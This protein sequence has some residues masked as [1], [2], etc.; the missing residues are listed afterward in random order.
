VWKK[1]ICNEVKLID[2]GGATYAHESHTL[3]INTRQYR[4]PEV[5]L[6]NRSW[7]E[8]SDIWSMAC[9][10]VELYTGELFFDTHENNLEHL[11]MIEKQCGPIPL[12]MA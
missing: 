2:F 9:I 10:L 12:R 11:A 7:D 6:E 8:K 5:I 4:A 1:P 3:I